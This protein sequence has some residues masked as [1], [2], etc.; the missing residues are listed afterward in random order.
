MKVSRLFEILYIL[1][2]KKSVSAR[3]LAERFEV[4]VRTIYRDV[5]TLCAAGIP[6]FTQ[7]GKGG[8]IKI[9][10]DYI[11]NKSILSDSEQNEI[12]MG[13]QSLK[14]TEYPNIEDALSKLGL[15]FNKE[16]I[17]WIEI[18][19]SHWGSK[20]EEKIKFNNLKNSI[21]N[22]Q[23]IE[24]KY[25]NS[26][27]QESHRTLEPIKILFKSRN[28]YLYAYCRDK[29]D[30]R[31]FKLSRI[32]NL[33]ITAEKF[34]RVFNQTVLSE[35]KASKSD[36]LKFTAKI[37]KE[38]AFRVFDEFMP[39]S[40]TQN[41][42]GSF[43]VKA[44]FPEDEWLYSYLLSFGC[45]IEVLEPLKLREIIIDRLKKSIEKYEKKLTEK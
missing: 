16:Q 35:E 22:K 36:L 3:E 42:D 5:D 7:K 37:D 4:S 26:Y 15:L 12:L 17:N 30:Y 38:L 43:I 28:W 45:C 41:K 23:V 19:F 32:T 11:F 39:E 10:D 34:D 31:L 27:G 14:A 1:I 33:N 6:I 13:L 29:K 40:I 8:G 24:F 18:D 44:Q 9:L 25:Y 2:D 21:L 20:G